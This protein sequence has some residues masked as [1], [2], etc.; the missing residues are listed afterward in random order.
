MKKILIIFGI[1]VP[2]LA[3]GLSGCFDLD[4]P[5]ELLQFSIASFEVEPGINKPRRNSKPQ[6]DCY[7]R[8]LSEY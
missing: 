3:V 5:E 1:A 8:H 7:K 6:L 4:V 2:L